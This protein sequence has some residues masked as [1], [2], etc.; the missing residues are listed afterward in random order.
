MACPDDHQ[1]RRRYASQ[2]EIFAIPRFPSF[3]HR[4]MGGSSSA[5]ADTIGQD[6][7]EEVRHGLFCSFRIVDGRDAYLRLSTAKAWSFMKARRR[8]QQRRSP[9]N[10]RKRRVAVGSYSRR[11][12]GADPVSRVELAWSPS[13]LGREPPSLPGA[14]VAGDHKPIATTREGWRTR[15]ALASSSPCSEVAASSCSTFVGL[16]MFLA[17]SVMKAFVRSRRA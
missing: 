13:G 1:L 16:A 9:A 3:Q 6:E 4:V 2:D 15:L 12:N 8:R 10:C 7:E 14:Q 5:K 17:A 11:A